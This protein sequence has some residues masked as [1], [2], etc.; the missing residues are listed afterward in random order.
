[1]SLADNLMNNIERIGKGHYSTGGDITELESYDPHKRL[2]PEN[3]FSRDFHAGTDT[4][5]STDGDSTKALEDTQDI[6]TLGT[7]DNPATVLPRAASGMSTAQYL[8]KPQPVQIVGGK[9]SRRG[10][11]VVNTDT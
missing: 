6:R 1:M 9:P 8:V 11:R 7:K 4:V 5:V 2:G 10:V 3:D